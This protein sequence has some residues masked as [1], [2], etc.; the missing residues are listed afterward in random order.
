LI[1]KKVI[2]KTKGAQK[3]PHPVLFW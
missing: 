3:L 2:T 1:L